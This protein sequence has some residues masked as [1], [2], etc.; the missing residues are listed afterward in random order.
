MLTGNLVSIFVGGIVSVVSSIIVRIIS[1]HHLFIPHCCFPSGQKILILTLPGPLTHLMSNKPS[2]KPILKKTQKKN[3][4]RRH[5]LRRI[6]KEFCG[7]K[8]L[9]SILSHCTKLLISLHGL[10]LFWYTFFR[11]CL[12]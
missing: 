5:L 2:K 11:L 12:C 7:K 8:K 10:L 6:Y 9:N 3:T 4:L 1:L